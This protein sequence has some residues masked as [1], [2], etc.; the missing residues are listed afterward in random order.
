MQGI[1]DQ[2]GTQASKNPEPGVVEA[3][4]R[5]KEAGGVCAGPC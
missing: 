1:C 3:E 4:T 2:K 5:R